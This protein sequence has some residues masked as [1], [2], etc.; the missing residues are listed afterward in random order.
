MPD[1]T[2]A[3]LSALAQ[4]GALNREIEAALGREMTPAERGVV[5]RARVA[6]RIKR[7]QKRE[8]GRRTHAEQ[9]ALDKRRHRTLTRRAPED[10]RR[11]RRLE[12]NPEA[13]LRHYMPAAFPLPFGAGHRAMIE[14][15]LRAAATGTGVVV[16]AP[17]GEGKTTLLRGLCL[18][19]VATGRARFP[20]MAGWTHRSAAAAFREWRRMLA[21]SPEVAADYPSLTMPFEAAPH[22]LGLRSLLWGETQADGTPDPRAGEE[23]GAEMRSAE[24]MIVLPDSTGAIAAASVQGDVKGLNV[25]LPNGEVIRPDLLLI[26]DAQDPRRA[27][28]PAFV[29]DV[30]DVIEKQWLCLAGPQ[31]RITIFVACTV[32]APGDVSEHFLS[33]RDCVSVRVARV[34][35]WPKGWDEKPSETRPLW[36]E[37]WSVLLDGMAEADGGKAGR[38]FY[39]AHKAAMTEG[40]RVSWPQRRDRKRKDPDALYSAMFDWHRIGETAFASEYQNAPLKQGV[41]VYNLTPE[42]V[43]SRVDAARAAYQLP[44][45]AGV[46]IAATDLNHYGLHSTAVAFGNDQSAAVVW[47]ARFDR[48]TVPDNAPEAERRR[49]V[50]EMLAGH[51]REI[52]ALPFRPALWI[53]D[54]GY[55]HATVQRFV[56]ARRTTPQAIVARGYAYDRYRPNGKYVIGRPREM[57]H[58]TQ[59]PLGRG[60]AW[61]SDYWH[62]VSQRGWLGSIGAPGA[63]S[64]FAGQ[65]REFAEHVCRQRLAEKLD[66]RLGVV[67]RWTYSPG[68]NDWG[69]AMAMAYMGAAWHGIGTGGPMR[70]VRYVERRKCRVQREE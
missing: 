34:A 6:W 24:R 48:L 21:G 57:C 62:E 8:T 32:A 3:Q 17:R 45:W 55:E 53:I 33:R 15:A 16:A 38:A 13:W 43:V 64:L 25:M 1:L 70:V 9:V 51:G 66:G 26:D 37:W 69:D 22:A 7:H 47:Y 67:W 65:H 5:D 19:L 49:I 35:A 28:N 4:T 52:D 36:A 40:M 18:Y 27:D 11:K 61:Q 23:C 20:L 42:V 30:V 41:T 10:D 58:M 63:C 68:R 2:T 54:G 59:W 46:T 29:A 31:S 14:G 50:F 60:I 39:R 44:A 56:D 12:A